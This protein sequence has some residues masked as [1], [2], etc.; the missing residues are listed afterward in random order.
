[1]KNKNVITPVLSAVAVLL[2]MA[3]SAGQAAKSGSGNV[4]TNAVSDSLFYSIGGGSVISQPASLNRMQRLGISAGINSDLMCG[5]F[6]INTTVSNQLNGLTSGFKDLMGD[7]M[8]GATGAV[9]SLPGMIVQRANPGLYDMLTNGILQ[10]GLS[11]DKSKLS[12][13]NMS[14]KLADYT[15]GDSA[16]TEAAVGDEYREAINSSGGDATRA[17][18]AKDKATG[19]EGATWIGGKKAGGKGQPAIQPVRDMAKAGYNMLNGQP[20]TSNSSVSVANCNGSACRIFKNAEEAATSIV[21]V[22][23]DRSI[24]TCKDKSQCESG[25]AENAP[26]ASVAGTGFGPLLDAS[27][28][29]NLETLTRLVSSQGAPSAQELAKLKTGGL[30][31][32]RGVIE[33]LRDDSDNSALVQRLAGELAMADTIETA[34]AMRRILTTGESEPNAAAQKQA[35]EEGDRRIG[36]LDRE[37]QALKNEMELRRA[38]SS[39]SLLVTLERQEVRN[40]SNQ[41]Q[42]RT[43]STDDGM[44]ALSQKGGE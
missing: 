32:T 7:V 18:Q 12:C 28:K 38:I 19:E 27:T 5:N 41:L 20:V 23:G 30:P 39:N 36:S 42:Q 31:V 2:M 33:A 10:A 9:A 3:S 24:R 14:R 26:G 25:G 1:M 15:M 22:L 11:F 44:N 29:V 8:Q 40:S 35:I 21:Q 6:D 17:E 4:I 13:E 43:P 34:L 37:L 16:W